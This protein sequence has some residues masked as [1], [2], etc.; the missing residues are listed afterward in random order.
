MHNDL[1]T[2]CGTEVMPEPD[3]PHYY[4]TLLSFAIYCVLQHMYQVLR[5]YSTRVA[6]IFLMA[7][8]RNV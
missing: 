5:K 3:G 4:R 2:V 7:S 6:R 8:K 1:A